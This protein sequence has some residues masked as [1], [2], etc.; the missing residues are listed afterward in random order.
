[1]TPRA[2]LLL[3]LPAL[4]SACQDQQAR[5]QNAELGR[6]V[7][8]LEAEVK[9]LRAERPHT[10]TV[11]AVTTVTVRA[12]A[13]NCALELARTLEQYRQDSLEHRYP[14]RT[15]MEFPDACKNQNVNWQNLSHQA[16]DFQVL[17][18]DGKP[19]AKQAGP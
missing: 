11:D 2:A 10:L 4:L 5:Q 15:E 16:Y 1:M 12:A 7:A 3:F 13:Q 8:A 18:Q 19:L 14:S 9:A 17:G 6:R